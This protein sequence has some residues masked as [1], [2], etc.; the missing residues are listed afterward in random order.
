M[1][2]QIQS[3]PTQD[4]GGPATAT[5]PDRA[6]DAALTAAINA[7]AADAEA[8]RPG[9]PVKP[10]L[11]AVLEILV[12]IALPTLLDHF[13]PAFPSLSDMQPHPFWLPVLLV[14]IQYGTVSG[15]LAAGSAIAAN[16]FLGW[17]EQEIGENHFTY[18]L[19]VWSQP[20]L[21]LAAS[22]MLGQFRMRQIEQKQELARQVAELGTQRKAIADYATNLRA[23]CESLEREMVGRRAPDDRDLLA[24]LGRL[25]TAMAPEA[26][27]A[28]LRDCLAAAFGKCQ[29]SVFARD[30]DGFRLVEQHGW[31]ANARWQTALTAADPLAVAMHGG[32]RAVSVL[33]PGDEVLLGSEAL[34]A[35]PIA[36]HID[37]RLSG[38][39]KIEAMEPTEIDADVTLRLAALAAQIAPL[40]ESASAWSQIG[41]NAAGNGAPHT[42]TASTPVAVGARPWR[43]VRWQRR[44]NA[45]EAQRPTRTG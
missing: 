20:M 17:P 38:L 33:T 28:A 14:S 24:R 9:L 29:A 10:P 6:V 12:L 37:R 41:G 8:A 42:A 27:R 44:A 25:S 18:L 11:T 19:R 7:P 16:S 35:V 39:I 5:R 21:W 22:L 23:R 34:A 3:P 13:V 26:A 2:A 15:L 31:P 40:L 4:A 30:G 45:V 1:T 43:Q 32:R 36:S